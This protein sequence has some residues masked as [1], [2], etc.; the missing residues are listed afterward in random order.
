MN[1]DVEIWKPIEGFEGLYSISSLGRV[2][3]FYAWNGKERIKKEH[4]ISGW[5]QKPLK[6]YKYCR[7]I[8]RLV[9]EDGK[10]HEYKVHRLVAKAFVSNPNNYTI[11]NHLDFDPLNNSAD[12]LEWTTDR[13]NYDYSYDAGRHNRITKEKAKEIIC[14]YESIRNIS[15]VAKQ[16]G[17]HRQTISKVLK[18]NGIEIRDPKEKYNIDLTELLDDFKN[19]KTYKELEK[20]YLCS[21]S[22][23][24][25]R[26]YQFRKRG[27]LN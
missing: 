1:Y 9:D 21:H 17:L 12:N 27:Q 25:T 4:I 13:G 22:I 23:L 15:I 19:G 8:I 24:A 5:V 11:V 7:R 20:K 10:R 3:S 26:K 18:T 14:L 6:K 16:V 2:K